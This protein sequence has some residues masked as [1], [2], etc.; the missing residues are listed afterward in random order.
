MITNYFRE[1]GILAVTK[2]V[3][4]VTSQAL[5]LNSTVNN[6]VTVRS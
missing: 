4:K 2:Y 5:K 6:K 3:L 1:L